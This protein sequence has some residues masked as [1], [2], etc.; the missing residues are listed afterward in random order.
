MPSDLLSLQYF[1]FFYFT[2]ASFQSVYVLVQ[3]IGVNVNLSLPSENNGPLYRSFTSLC[4]VSD[5]CEG[6]KGCVA[7]LCVFVCTVVL[8]YV[9]Q[10]V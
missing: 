4:T 1:L 10:C 2:V 3:Y 8:R 6:G 9:R 7:C 5:D